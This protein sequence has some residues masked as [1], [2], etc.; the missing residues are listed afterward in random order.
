MQKFFSNFR[1]AGA[2]RLLSVLFFLCCT[3][4][5]MGQGSVTIDKVETTPKKTCNSDGTITVTYTKT[6]ADLKVMFKLHLKSENTEIAQ[7]ED[8]KFS[9]LESDTYI[10]KVV[11]NPNESKVYASREIKVGKTYVNL[12][13]SKLQTTI[14]QLCTDFKTGA[15]VK[16]EPSTIQGGT[17]PFR[18]L[19]HKHNKP[20]FDDKG[21]TY[22]TETEFEVA[23][24]GTYQLRVKDKCEDSRTLTITISSTI[25]KASLSATPYYD[26]G[27]D[28][29]QL[30]KIKVVAA[31][32]GAELN[33]VLLGSGKKGIKLELYAAT[34]DGKKKLNEEKLYD[35]TIT[36]PND[37][38]TPGNADYQLTKLS[39]TGKYWGKVTTPCGEP[40]EG[41]IKIPTGNKMVFQARAKTQGC[42]GTADEK[43]TI[44]HTRFATG[45][46]PTT[47]K[48]YNVDSGA[49][50]ETITITDQ[51]LFNHFETQPLPFGTYR[52]EGQT[53][54]P[55]FDPL[56][57]TINNPKGG[58]GGI[59]YQVFTMLD[60]CDGIGKYTYTSGT[61]SV[62]IYQTGYIPFEENSTATIIEGPSNKDVKAIR[63][64]GRYRWTNMLP[65]H[66]K[67]RFE[68][69]SATCTPPLNFSKEVEFDVP[70]TNILKQWINSKAES[71]CGQ[72]GKITTPDYFVNNS[73]SRMKAI[74]LLNDK[75]EKIAEN[76]TGE[77]TN[78]DPGTYYTRIRM[79]G[80]YN[81]SYYVD[82]PKPLVILPP[83][84]PPTFIK[85]QG[86][87]C[88]NLGGGTQGAMYIY[89]PEASDVSLTYRKKGAAEWTNLEYK[90][91]Q[92]IPADPGTYEFQLSRC[93]SVNTKRVLVNRL[94]ILRQED[95]KHPCVDHPYTISVPLY[96]EAQYE[97]KKEGNTGVLSHEPKIDFAKY[98]AADD[99][100][101][102]CRV[103]WGGCVTREVKYTLNS[104]KCGT[105]LN[106]KISGKVFDDRNELT[107]GIDGTPIGKAGSRRLYIHLLLK[108][109]ND[110][111][112][113][114]N[115][116]KPVADDGTFTI[117]G[118]DEKADCR[119]IL[120]TEDTAVEESTRIPGWKFVGETYDTPSH[121]G[122]PNGVLDVKLNSADITTIK[123][124]I[125]RSRVL[126][127]NRHITTKL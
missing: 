85:A 13:I 31:V 40:W 105:A 86:V 32:G 113:H 11:G 78:L 61:T 3:L 9:G 1:W 53:P 43:M 81:Q 108:D 69:S 62:Q 10:L 126:R 58:T 106:N 52:L 91:Y 72:K 98:T 63:Y 107:G 18:Y 16:I 80:C 121:D 112:V 47:V 2:Q 5:A 56:P 19:L 39:P 27:C 74:E 88:D 35:R 87:A 73:A 120:S 111:Y 4:W 8:G 21:L 41:E 24:F 79:G 82:D 34:T 127:S 57:V 26:G 55:S 103:Q 37:K 28:K 97:W 46:F 110:N 7:S 23:D 49:L 123:F 115:V 70:A 118:L 71:L 60:I 68:S 64:E 59:V 84:G 109:T 102:I 92:K 48:V 51:A 38:P 45:I 114:T 42:P 67:A 66:Y 104:N 94:T 125:K 124:G 20:N 93:G 122:T 54:C 36:D 77:F 65:G 25:P 89:L 30:S 116:I 100:T 83:E 15:K 76:L 75:R 99:G 95:G 90:P 6:P 101:Y 14:T 22:Q 12:D 117:G 50:V 33:D 96:D 119:L 29:V 17:P 44:A